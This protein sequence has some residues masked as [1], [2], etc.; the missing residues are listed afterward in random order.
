MCEPQAVKR[1][2]SPSHDSG[3]NLFHRDRCLAL[4]QGNA[5]RPSQC[6]MCVV[7]VAAHARS[8]LAGSMFVDRN[9][10]ASRIVRA[11]PDGGFGRVGA[12]I[13]G[14]P[15]SDLL[16]TVYD[17]VKILDPLPDLFASRQKALKFTL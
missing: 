17:M 6:G 14:V 10:T 3:V 12:Q 1:E 16:T 5:A 13:V 8:Q 15:P 4:Q 9:I 11:S 7:C 2:R